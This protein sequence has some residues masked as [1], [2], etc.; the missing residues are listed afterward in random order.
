MKIKN[1]FAGPGFLKH[2][3]ALAIL[4]GG[5]IVGAMILSRLAVFVIGSNSAG[6]AALGGAILGIVFG[7]PLGLCMA[8]IWLRYRTL[9]AGSLGLGV[10]GAVLG[11]VLT[12]G[13]AE[14]THL[15]Q[16]SDW[17]FMSFFISVPL[18]ALLG[19]RLKLIWRVV[20]S[21]NI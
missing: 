6:F 12:I 14:V 18:L 20:S 2:V 16:N 15:N 5:G 9:Y 11:G 1:I 10:L 8:M 21:K 19:Y 7:Y 3:L 4:C 17:L 13:L